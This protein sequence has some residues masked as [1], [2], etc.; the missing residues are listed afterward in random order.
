MSSLQ[1][2]IKLL[3][4]YRDMARHEELT[5]S[6]TQ[7]G[8]AGMVDL[9]LQRRNVSASPWPTCNFLGTWTHVH[10]SITGPQRDFFHLHTGAYLYLVVYPY[11]RSLYYLMFPLPIGSGYWQCYLDAELTEKNLLGTITP[12]V[13]GTRF[14]SS[15][16]KTHAWNIGKSA[17]RNRY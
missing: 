5:Q 10:G 4:F 11:H 7:V 12:R 1:P 15:Q 13:W 8:E 9:A 3:E 14:S 2:A 6:E 16:L 17:S